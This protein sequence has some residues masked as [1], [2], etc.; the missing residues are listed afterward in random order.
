MTDKNNPQI[1]THTDATGHVDILEAGEVYDEG[2]QAQ[3]LQLRDIADAQIKAR[4][5]LNKPLD[6]SFDG[7]HCVECGDAIDP[8]RL[9]SIKTDTCFDCFQY[10]ETLAKRK[11]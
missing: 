2:D 4:N 7:V 9:Q 8:R 6:P 11:R 3:Y 10:A 1:H 5:A